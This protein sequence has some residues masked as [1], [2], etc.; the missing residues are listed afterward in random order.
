MPWLVATMYLYKKAD[1]SINKVG[2]SAIIAS[3]SFLT[4]D[5]ISLGFNQ[6]FNSNELRI[7]SLVKIMIFFIAG[8]L[9]L[10]SMKPAEQETESNNMVRP[11]LINASTPLLPESAIDDQ[12]ENQNIFI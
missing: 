9:I 8:M 10:G 12:T 1:K 6:L 7:I 4:T 5:I 3:T 11:T 2:S